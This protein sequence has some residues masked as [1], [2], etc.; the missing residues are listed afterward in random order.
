[1]EADVVAVDED[2][3]EGGQRTV[4]EDAPLERGVGRDE[5]VERLAHRPARDFDQAE[6]AGFGAQDRRNLQRGH[7]RDSSRRFPY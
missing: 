3:Q 1:M 4:V 2:V 6:A 5:L 7:G